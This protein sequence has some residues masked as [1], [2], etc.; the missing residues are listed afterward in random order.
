MKQGDQ[1][2]AL[3]RILGD[4]YLEVGRVEWAQPVY[5]QAKERAAIAQNQ[6]ELQRAQAGLA[7]ISQW[8]REGEK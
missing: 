3:L 6:L 2:P 5:E 8:S 1:Q 7:V 4:L